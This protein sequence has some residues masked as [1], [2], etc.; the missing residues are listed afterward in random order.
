MGAVEAYR[1]NGGPLGE[2]LDLLHPGEAFDPLGLADDPDTFAELKVK[3][4]KNGCLAMFSMFGYYVQAIVTGQGPVENWASHIA[5][6][7][8]VNGSTSAYVTQFAPSPVAMF[9]VSGRKFQKSVTPLDLWYG[10]DRNLWLGPYTQNVPVYLTG[11]LPGDYGWDTAGLGADPTTLEKYREAELIHA[12]WAML[13]TLGCITPEFPAKYG[14]GISFAGASAVWL[15][16]S[17]AIFSKGGINYLGEPQ[18]VHA[19]SILA[20]LAC[21]VLLMGAVEAYRAAES[22]PLG[23]GLDKLHPG[24]AFDPPGLADDPDTFAELKVKE[25]KNGRLAMFSMFGYYVQAIVTGEGPVENWASHIADPFAV[26]GLT[27]AYVTQFAPSPVAMFAASGR[28]SDN[29]AAWYGP[30][31]NKWLG[32]FSDAST[33]DYLTGEYPG[34]YGWDTAGLAADPTTFAAYREAELIHARWAMLGTLGCLT[35]ELLAK[36]A[37]C[38]LA[39]LCGS[40]LVLR[41]SLRAVW[42]TLAAPTWRTPSPSLPSWPARLC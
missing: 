17:A 16:A 39:S 33:P 29:L 30:E 8:A 4:I 42:T 14:G 35:P 2:D 27:S 7:F 26:N 25:I 23:E 5:D 32:P 1:V 37:G 20:I 11:G 41:S 15:K 18:L 10:P 21:Q 31:R 3:E 22:G 34:D 9:A 38:P 19:Q 36:Y 28:V 13:G 6:P 24:E 40:R 12:R